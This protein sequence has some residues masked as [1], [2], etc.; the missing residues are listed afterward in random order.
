M[1]AIGEKNPG[2]MIIPPPLWHGAATVGPFESPLP[3]E[4]YVFALPTPVNATRARF[5]VVTSTGGNTGARE[6]QLLVAP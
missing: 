1:A 3:S 2:V 5:E 6:V 4:V